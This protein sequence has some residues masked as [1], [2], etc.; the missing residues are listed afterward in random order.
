MAVARKYL[1]W[2]GRSETHDE[3]QGDIFFDREGVATTSTRNKKDAT[4][5]DYDESDGCE[6]IDASSEWSEDESASS[7]F[8]DDYSSSLESGPGELDSDRED[9]NGF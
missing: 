9:G 6:S 5:W 8:L 4:T 2:V 7:S 1:E 3:V